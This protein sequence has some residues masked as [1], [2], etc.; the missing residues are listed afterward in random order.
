[1][2]E[3]VSVR[4]CWGEC[5]CLL[6][7][8][9]AQPCGQCEFTGRSPPLLFQ[10]LTRKP[11]SLAFIFWDKLINGALVQYT[12]QTPVLIPLIMVSSKLL[13]HAFPSIVRAWLC[14]HSCLH[15][16]FYFPPA[17]LY[18]SVP[19]CFFA[20]SLQFQSIRCLLFCLL[21]Y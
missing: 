4:E 3:C 20:I 10:D 8:V 19:F 7:R 1:M 9:C 13:H 16:I 17:S 14:L 12:T 2:H 5:T 11:E 6:F 15:S 21:C 18:R